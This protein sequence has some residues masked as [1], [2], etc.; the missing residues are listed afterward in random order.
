MGGEEYLRFWESSQYGI[1]L[2]RIGNEEDDVDRAQAQTD[3]IPVIRRT[4]GGGTVVQGPGCLN[5]TCVL[6]KTKR[7]VLNDLRSSYEWISAQVIAALHTQGIEGRFYPISDLALA[8]NAK[9]F[10]GNAQRRGKTHILHHGTILYGFDLDKISRYL[11][12]PKDIPEYRKL[13]SHKD[14]VTNISIDPRHFKAALADLMEAG[15]ASLAATPE[16]M[17]LLKK[18]LI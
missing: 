3:G 18:Y 16:E 17:V 13:R 8:S 14:F 15:S 10:S 1:V 9:K 12:M 6:S 11:R 2:G 7:P 5:Y 4:S